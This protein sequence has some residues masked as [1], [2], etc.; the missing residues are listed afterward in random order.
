MQL[1][2]EYEKASNKNLPNLED[3]Y[4]GDFFWYD[5]EKLKNIFGKLIFKAITKCDLIVISKY[6]FEYIS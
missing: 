4:G 1:V 6:L 3:F 2:T 5:S